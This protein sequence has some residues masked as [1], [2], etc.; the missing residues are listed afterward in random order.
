M[1]KVN[2]ELWLLLFLVAIA[3]MLNFLVASQPMTLMF[4]FLPTLYSGCAAY[5]CESYGLG[6][7]G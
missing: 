5:L 3:A 1:R 7:T 6:P 2:P 4:Y